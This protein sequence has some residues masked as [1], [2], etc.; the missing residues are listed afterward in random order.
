MP[1]PV[2]IIL[3]AA[4]A[5]ACHSA[6]AQTAVPPTVTVQQ[7]APQLL[8]FAG[9]PS[10]FQNLVTGLAQ[11][12]P[13]QLVTVLPTGF[14]QVVT[15]T[16]TAP[17]S[18][19]EIAQVLESARQQ[20]IGLGIGNPTAEQIGMAL[21]GGVV[22]TALGGSQVA[23]LLNAQNPPSPAAQLQAGAAAGAT[24]SFTPG[25][26]TSATPVA[27]G[28][29]S[30]VSVQLVPNTQP[31]ATTTPTTLPRINTSDSLT[32]AGATS[33]SPLPATTSVSPTPT[34]PSTA[35][36]VGSIPPATRPARN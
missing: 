10:N 30:A 14:T 12:T 16:P 24:T 23:G 25:A 36:G 22:P 34:T 17:M 5:I 8:A 7:L 4:V 11:G 29:T 18:P 3:A 35:P 33:R 1:S 9:S 32:P 19:T 2:R 15:F 27:P 13:I 6:L 31:S 26:T 21:M 28:A 20:L